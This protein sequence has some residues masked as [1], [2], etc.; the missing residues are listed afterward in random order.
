M[1]KGIFRLNKILFRTAILSWVLVILTVGLFVLST[2][3]YQQETI[4]DRMNSEAQNISASIGEVTATSVITEDFSVVV[5]HC[6]KMVKDSQTILYV[7]ITRKDGYSL[8][9]NKREWKQEKLEGF[10][11]PSFNELKKHGLIIHALAEKEVFHYS[12]PLKYSGIDWGWINIGL[13]LEQYYANLRNLYIRTLGV[14][15]LCIILGLIASFF[16][17]RKLS[18]PIYA[19]DDIT[20]R[21]AAGDMT[22]KADIRTGDELESLAESFNKM[23]GALQRS[24]AELKKAMEDLQKAKDAAEAANKAKSLFLANMSH[25]IR[26]PLNGV[27][28]MNEVLLD[29]QLTEKQR[30]IAM[31]MKRSGDNLLHIINDILDFSKIEAGKMKL[32]IMPFDLR[33]TV[34]DTLDLF[35]E[36]ANAKG[37]ELT[38]DFSGYIDYKVAGDSV[39]LRQIL[40]N[41]LGNAVKFTEQGEVAVRIKKL[42]DNGDD[43]IILLEVSDSGIGIAPDKQHVIFNAFSQADDSTTRRFGGSG[44]GLTITKQLIELMGG[45][46]EIQSEHGKGSLFRVE[47]PFKRQ[48]VNEYMISKSSTQL[49]NHRLLIVDDNATNRSIL[50][51]MALLWGMHV[52]TVENGEAAFQMLKKATSLG[53]P[54]N[55]IILD[56]NMPGMS[57][58]ELAGKIK[59]EPDFSSIKLIMMIPPGIDCGT[60]ELQAKGIHY[61][62]SKPVRMSLFYNVL[63]ELY[64][65]TEKTKPLPTGRGDYEKKDEVQHRITVL[66]AEDNPVNQLVASGLLQSIGCQVDIVSNGQE[67]I[68]AT[69]HNKY[70][71]IL[72]DCMMPVVDG[73]KAAQVIKVREESENEKRRRKGEKEIHTPIIAIT[74]HAMEGA[75][76]QCLAAGMDAHLPKPFTKSQL[77]EMLKRWLPDK[78]DPISTPE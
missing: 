41:L 49:K 76:E 36:S 22:A 2:I 64:G 50:Q 71:I 72:L 75:R 68:D 27:L 5:E 1:I 53:N 46:I 69:I 9:H 58:I 59:A 6:M 29:T 17:A 12:Y 67:A 48:I 51:H 18:N 66:L 30:S 26:T 14:S 60:E 38:C 11:N 39:R 19:L 73:Y 52:G 56:L 77:Q 3:T 16:F 44:L 54:Y 42:W 25:E 4:L 47:I 15:F 45:R 21:I 10:R 34:E 20:R 57:G 23:T 78:Y 24:Q 40:V 74:A 33:Q 55:I 7:V 65:T 62:L 31:M 61:F 70:D 28:G 43:M 35:V 37:V 63:I 13:S 8:S 32:E